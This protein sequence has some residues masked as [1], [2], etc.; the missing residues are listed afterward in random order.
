MKCMVRKASVA[1]WSIPIYW[2]VYIFTNQIC[3]LSAKLQGQNN[4]HDIPGGLDIDDENG[5]KKEE[6]KEEEENEEVDNVL[7]YNGYDDE[8]GVIHVDDVA[9]SLGHVGSGW[10]AFDFNGSQIISDHE[11]P[12]IH[13][14][15]LGNTFI[16]PKYFVHF[17]LSQMSFSCQ[18]LWR[19]LLVSSSQLWF[20]FLRVIN[21]HFRMFQIATWI[22]VALIHSFGTSGYAFVYLRAGA[23]LFCINILM[24]KLYCVNQWGRTKIHKE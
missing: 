18:V 13:N 11:S 3:D 15:L 17:F 8:G 12:E 21:F 16:Y 7:N 1:G 24:A 22:I 10:Q 4:T 5:G 20:R 2:S 23:S 6:E 19:M 14:V 9:S